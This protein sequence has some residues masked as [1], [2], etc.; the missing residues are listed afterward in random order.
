[1]PPRR[2]S[3]RL[4]P[5]L[6]PQVA[7]PGFSAM[8]ERLRHASDG[9]ES[10]QQLERGSRSRNPTLRTRMLGVSGYVRP[11]ALDQGALDLVKADVRLQPSEHLVVVTNSSETRLDAQVSVRVVSQKRNE[12]RQ[13]RVASEVSLLDRRL[14]FGF[15]PLLC[16]RRT[17]SPEH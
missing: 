1:M 5:I 13:G 16:G 10:G 15:P 4:A 7:R 6:R 2:T 12:R 11:D 17:V 14:A 3:P 8:A 9:L